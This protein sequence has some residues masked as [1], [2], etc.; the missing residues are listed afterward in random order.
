MERNLTLSGTAYFIFPLPKQYG[1]FQS[2]IV[3]VT[4]RFRQYPHVPIKSNAI[5][6][7][8]GNN[9]FQATVSVWSYVDRLVRLDTGSRI[10]DVTSGEGPE[11]FG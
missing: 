9:Y 5:R 11:T 2:T 10:E 3:T 4:V 6:N 1:T 7:L 8:E